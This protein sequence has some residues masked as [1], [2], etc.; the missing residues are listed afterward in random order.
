[1]KPEN[2]PNILQMIRA[3]FFSSV[4]APINAASFLAFHITGTFNY[5]AFLLVVL[6]GLGLHTATNV[7]NDI[8]DTLQGTDGANEHRNEFSGG[9]GVLVNFPDLM[10]KMYFLARAGLVL[11]LL[12]S[13]ALAFFIDSK[14]YPVLAVLFL[15][16]AFFSKYYTAAPV[17]L[18]YRG[19]GEI[20]V[21]FAFGPMAVLIGSVSQNLGFHP[22]VTAIMPVSGLSTLSILVIGEMIDLDADVKAGK[23]GIVSRIGTAKG[24]YFYF[25][26]QLALMLNVLVLPMI[27]SFFEI[28]IYISLI[29]YLFLLPRIWIVVSRFHNQPD[30]L[31]AAAKYNVLLHMIFSTLFIAGFALHILL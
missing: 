22:A 3:P 15:L 25:A 19:V 6:V 16:S 2:R 27:N 13:I 31:K 8:Y 7:Y 24:S 29:P 1:M 11:A 10:P 14:L 26:V 5:I 20:A 21:W 12:A 9:S 17:K 4:W 18:A 23:L 28:W 30:V